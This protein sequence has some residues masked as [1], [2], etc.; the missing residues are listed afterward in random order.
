MESP[1]IYTELNGIISITPKQMNNDIYTNMK[2]NLI[3]RLEGKCYRNYGYITKIYDITNHGDGFIDSENPL[4]V[5]CFKVKF[6]CRLCYPLKN[7]YIICQVHSINSMLAKITNGPINVII[8]PD[9]INKENFE[10]NRQGFFT[11]L[12]Y[13][14]TPLKKGDY[15]KTKII[16]RQINDKDVIIM[17]IGIL[18]S[19]ATEEE[20]ANSIYEQNKTDTTKMMDVE[21]YMKS[22][23]GTEQT[24]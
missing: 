23:D 9:R 5:A 17:C 11:K 13:G 19:M 1:Y 18:E 21:Q 14:V 4:A 6:T 15:V 24:T 22:E 20:I 16:S 7:K 8:T 2:S 10:S 3:N 12:Q